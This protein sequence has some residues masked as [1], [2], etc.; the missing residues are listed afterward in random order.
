M[1]TIH[2][3]LVLIATLASFSAVALLANPG[4]DSVV[5]GAQ[6]PQPAPPATPAPQDPPPPPPGD[7]PDPPSDPPQSPPGQEAPKG[8]WVHTSQYGWVWMPYGND[9]TNVPADGGTPNMYVYYPEVGWSWVLAPWLWGWGPRPYFGAV[10][11]GYFGWYGVGMGHWYGWGGPYYRAG[12][13]GRGY[14]RGGSW[15]G[16]SHGHLASSGERS[17]EG[18]RGSVHP[19]VSHPGAYGSSDGPPRS[20]SRSGT[21]SPRA[22]SWGGGASTRAHGGGGTPRAYSWSGSA[23]TRAHGGGGTPRAYSWSGGGS[24]RGYGGGGSGRGSGG[25]GR[26]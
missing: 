16:V 22:Y 20:F 2:R 3:T 24:S 10:G 1:R 13:Y 26:R 21:G 5:A 7:R 23:S 14:F 12:Y 8:Q 15:H 19:G 9:Y 4:K 25:G 17:H 18:S 11:W 6:D